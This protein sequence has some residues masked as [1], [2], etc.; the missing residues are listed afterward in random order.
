[1]QDLV[2]R[3]GRLE[4]AA[5]RS[6]FRPGDVVISLLSPDTFLDQHGQGWALCD[7]RPMTGTQW[8]AIVGL[9][10]LPEFRG[11]YP[12]GYIGGLENNPQ[13][14][15]NMPQSVGPHTHSLDPPSASQGT[16]W[17]FGYPKGS[18]FMTVME[19][20]NGS[21]GHFQTDSGTGTETRP[22]TVVVN[23]YCRLQ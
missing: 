2:E 13:P 21:G 17:D 5:A 9:A 1:M 14:G 12:R 20:H 15:D 10:K 8:A 7:N 18:G 4:Q 23:F 3:V 16:G 19:I 6:S 11:K 22:D